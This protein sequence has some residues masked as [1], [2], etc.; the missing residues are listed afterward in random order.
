M[1]AVAILVDNG[2]MSDTIIPIIHNVNRAVARSIARHYNR[3]IDR[4]KGNPMNN[5]HCMII[6]QDYCTNWRDFI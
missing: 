3:I 1:Y 5:T 4:E 2:F 6:S